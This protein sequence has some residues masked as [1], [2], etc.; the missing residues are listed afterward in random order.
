[1]RGHVDTKPPDQIVPDHETEVDLY[2]AM[3][4]ISLWVEAD[5]KVEGCY[6][7]AVKPT[8]RF[9]DAYDWHPSLL[10]GGGVPGLAGFKDEWAAALHDAGLAA[11]FEVS[12]YWEGPNKVYVFPSDWLILDV[13]LPP[14]SVRTGRW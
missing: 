6:E 3:N 11:K 13:P 10:A 1:M 12:G 8:Y 7:V 9:W 5:Y 4:V 14:T 2:Y